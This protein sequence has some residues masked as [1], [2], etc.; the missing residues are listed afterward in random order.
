MRLEMFNI[1]NGANDWTEYIPLMQIMFDQ[2]KDSIFFV[3]SD[4]NILLLNQ[5]ASKLTGYTKEDLIGKPV[6]ALIFGHPTPDLAGIHP[7]GE[8]SSN[9]PQTISLEQKPSLISEL[10]PKNGQSIP[11]EIS[12]LHFPQQKGNISIVIARDISERK[13]A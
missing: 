6:G 9:H 3:N 12:H 7:H 5:S 2:I 10:I 11:I 4:G 13:I 8:H 1:L